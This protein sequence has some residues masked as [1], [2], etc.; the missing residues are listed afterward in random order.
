MAGVVLTGNMCPSEFLLK[1]I[2]TMPFPVLLA[3]ADSYQVASRV[4]DLTVKTPV[5]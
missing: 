3:A 1:V 2:K 5:N 4:H